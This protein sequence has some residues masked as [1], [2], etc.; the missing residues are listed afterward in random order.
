MAFSIWKVGGSLF[1]LA[2]L[3]QRLKT[4]RDERFP[5]EAVLIIPGGGAFADS[6]R[7]A[8][9]VHHLPG[10]SAHQ[11]ALQ[12]MRISAAMVATIVGESLVDDPTT[13]QELVRQWRSEEDAEPSLAVWDV[14]GAWQMAQPSLEKQWGVLPTDWSITSDS[15]AAAFA[16]HWGAQKLVLCKSIDRPSSDDYQAW[17]DQGLVDECFPRLAADLPQIEWINLRAQ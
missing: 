16:W 4:L 6:V 12:A 8:D 2:D 13:Q 11:L 1:D 3:G 9:Q 7:Q 5:G 10:E 14:I 17:A 15:I